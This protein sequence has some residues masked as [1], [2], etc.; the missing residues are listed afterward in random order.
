VVTVVVG[1]VVVTVVV[2]TVV[3]TVVVGMVV[4]TVVV[5]MVVVGLV[6]GGVPTIMV[7][8]TMVGVIEVPP[9]ALIEFTA[10]FID[11]V[12]VDKPRTVRVASSTFVDPAGT[13][14][15]VSNVLNVTLPAGRVVL[16]LIAA[17]M[18]KVR[19][20]ISAFVESAIIAVKLYPRRP[21]GNESAIRVIVP[22]LPAS[23]RVNGLTVIVVAILGM[24]REAV[25]RTSNTRMDK[26]FNL[27]R[28][29]LKQ[30]LDGSRRLP[31]ALQFPAEISLV[32]PLSIIIFK[33]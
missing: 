21:F 13:W 30:E 25:T 9:I 32:L 7:P 11:V 19:S 12:P 3:V 29:P 24:A 14:V 10:R 8:G 6:M 31:G 4:V 33:L 18:G 17:Q 23:S 15:P 2:G 16:S 20:I 27:I 22:V 28:V 26:G 5:G 1:T